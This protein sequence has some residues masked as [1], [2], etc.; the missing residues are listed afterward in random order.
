MA[1][2]KK[3]ERKET[4]RTGPLGIAF[5]VIVALSLT[6]TAFAGKALYE[7][8]RVAH[9]PPP[10]QH[11]G[12]GSGSL[13]SAGPT[14]AFSN[15]R[16]YSSTA[17]PP[18][19][20]DVDGDGVED[21]VTLV[22]AVTESPDVY[23]TALS[24]KS[25]LPI[26]TRGPY[27]VQPGSPAHMFL[28]GDR[29]V[30]TRTSETLGNAHI[31]SLRTGGEL[32]A[33]GLTEPFAGACGL[34]DG[35]RRLK[36]ASGTVLDLDTGTMSTT[37]TAVPCANEF[38]KCENANSKHCVSRDPLA[39][40]SDH[41]DPGYT[42]RDEDWQITIGSL[43]SSMSRAR[44][45][46]V[47]LGSTHGRVV[48]DEVLSSVESSEDHTV[49]STHMGEG[50][51]A[52]L[53]RESPAQSVVRVLDMKTG[54]DVWK[55]TIDEAGATPMAIHTGKTRVF[56]TLLRGGREE[57]R[58]YEVDSGKIVGTIADV[59]SDAKPATPT[60]GYYKGGYYGG[61]R[62]TPSVVIGE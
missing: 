32:A 7:R 30:L 44:P 1:D 23:A 6:S 59:S 16:I 27:S 54:D 62:G 42:Y 21:M 13:A 43:Q 60:P 14:S 37:P 10:A 20:V 39:I 52:I 47:V 33:Y 25:L 11:L 51:F 35:S 8:V 4:S 40:K 12:P 34:A 58:V 26:W 5:A 50:R 55:D 24:G 53:T 29:L 57:V 61:Y 48:W 17:V 9:Q 45:T 18:K 2:E 28:A 22:S 41:I 15:L 38:P 19:F 31:L 49:A 3:E 46:L 36:L 56:A